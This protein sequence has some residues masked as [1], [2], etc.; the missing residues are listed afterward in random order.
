MGNGASHWPMSSNVINLKANR[1]YVAV[2]FL[3]CTYLA[4]L[5]PLPVALPY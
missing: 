1:P 2:F 3:A 4:S 5:L